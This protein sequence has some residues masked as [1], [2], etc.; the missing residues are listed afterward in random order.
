MAHNDTPKYHDSSERKRSK[1]LKSPKRPKSLAKTPIKKP[2]FKSQVS[3][4]SPI[5]ENETICETHKERMKRIIDKSKKS[6]ISASL[7]DKNSSQEATESQ[8][9]KKPS[10]T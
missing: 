5:T 6:Q 9:L 3:K 10:N 7:S 2:A 8:L 4:K 1:N